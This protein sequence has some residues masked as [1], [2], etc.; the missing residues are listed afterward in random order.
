MGIL[1][2]SSSPVFGRVA[3][4][5]GFLLILLFPALLRG[6][7]VVREA[8]ASFPA[9]T[10]QLSYLS[11]AQ[12]R[13]LPE[14][15]Q[16]R[17]R[18]LGRQLTGFEQ[19]MRSMGSD[20]AEDV[21]EVVLGWRGEAIGRTGF[22]GLAAGRFDAAQVQEYFARYNLPVL[23]H[24]GY[25]L[26]AFGSG[27]DEADLLFC[28]LSPSSAAFGRRHDL[29]ALLDVQTGLRPALDANTAM[30]NW[31]AE[32]EGSAP[33]WGI[34][35]GKAAANN[36]AAW[37]AV[38][39]NLPVDPSVLLSPVEAILYRV[40]WGSSLTSYA[41]VLCKSAETAEAMAKLLILWRDT[42]PAEASGVV[43]LLQGTEI[44]AT[45]SRVELTASGSLDM[46]DQFLSG[47]TAARRTSPART[48]RIPPP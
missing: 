44:Y 35:T 24:A 27:V 23:A 20:P 21:D 45:G 1:A 33:Q 26:Y 13:A 5:V 39:G 34:S 47:R 46:L 14:Y 41:S 29:E 15:P 18:L 31:E 48:S 4:G 16:I 3:R 10:H 42:Q 12:L 2:L 37:L 30:V 32:L 36:A 17:R 43:A 40:D 9:D 7:V 6:Q 22:F 28:F 11:L 19:F 25:P 8:M 38:G